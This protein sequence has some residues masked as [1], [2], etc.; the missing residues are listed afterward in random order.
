MPYKHG[1]RCI[2][3]HPSPERCLESWS[4]RRDCRILRRFDEDAPGNSCCAWRGMH[5]DKAN[6][7]S[8]RQPYLPRPAPEWRIVN[9]TS[10][11]ARSR[12][13][14]TDHRRQGR[15]ETARSSGLP[16]SV[17]FRPGDRCEVR[18]C[19]DLRQRR[20]DWAS[21]SPPVEEKIQG[22]H[23]RL[24]ACVARLGPNALR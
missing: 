14:T 15:A 2:R 21:G 23:F 1:S 8:H 16:D 19:P 7:S 3:R 17:E 18:P 5:P 12:P 22:M 10:G 11:G 13:L 6:C 4:W 9:D 20:S 24:L